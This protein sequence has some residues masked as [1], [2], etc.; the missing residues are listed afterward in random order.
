MQSLV[1]GPCGENT[2]FMKTTLRSPL[3]QCDSAAPRAPKH[4][5]SVQKDPV[6]CAMSQL[7]GGS[8]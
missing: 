2:T 3:D 6:T 1:R 4:F 8:R 5:C 7:D